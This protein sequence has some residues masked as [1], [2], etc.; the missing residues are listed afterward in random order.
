MA[1]EELV[2]SRRVFEGKLIN[3]RVDTVRLANQ[4]ER[5]REVVEHPGAVAVLPVRPNG[6][7]VLVRQYRYAIGRAILEVPAGTREPD[8]PTETT[9]RREL[10][11]ETGYQTS[12]LEELVRFFVSPG[13]ANE[14]LVVYLARDVQGG[15][16]RPEDDEDIEVVTVH[17]SDIPSLIASGEIADSKTIISV[18]A[19]LGLRLTLPDGA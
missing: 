8:E 13:W 14:E 5:P 19:W 3:V 6:D 2:S 11:E 16:A 18:L 17:P 10:A 1:T 4:A 15:V 9:A 12:S 7:L